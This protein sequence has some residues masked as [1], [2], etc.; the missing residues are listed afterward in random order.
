MKVST[1]DYIHPED[2]AALENLKAIPLFPQCVKSFMNIGIERLIHGQCMAQ[3][4]RIGPKQLP[5]LYRF[6]PPICDSLG[7][8]EPEFYLE[9][10]PMP[11][12]YT[13]GDTQIFITVTSGLV[14]MLEEDEIQAVIAHEAGHIACHHV[15][16]HTMGQYL[17]QFGS[18]VFG[19]LAQMSMPVQLAMMYWMRRSELSAD[20][21][22]AVAMRS[23]KPMIETMIRLAGGPK[24][25]TGQVDLDLYMQQSEMYDKLL[26]SSW[27]KFLQGLAVMNMD[28]PLLSVRARE[29]ARWGESE[30]FQRILASLST[31]GG[32]HCQ[33][34]REPI[35]V[36]WKFC[37]HCGKPLVQPAIPEN[38]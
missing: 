3:K 9:M 28:H 21:A 27:D 4:I 6:L 32:P 19:I 20:R 8:E 25:I 23:S 14:E 5:E 36:D 38:P 37:K 33:Q 26:E 18:Q 10:N 29:L 31:S 12:A 34:C 7:I 13:Q 24:A 16:Y 35:Q 2:Q 22:G 30:Q 1:R 11:N 17:I 15:L